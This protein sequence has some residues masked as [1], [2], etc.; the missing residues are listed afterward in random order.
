MIISKHFI[1]GPSYLYI[2]I[3]MW[4]KQAFAFVYMKIKKMKNIFISNRLFPKNVGLMNLW[5]IFD[6]H[7]KCFSNDAIEIC[8]YHVSLINEKLGDSSL[9]GHI[10]INILFFFSE[11]LQFVSHVFTWSS[12]VLNWV[13][14]LLETC[15]TFWNILENGGK[16]WIWNWNWNWIWVKNWTKFEGFWSIFLKKILGSPCY[17]ISGGCLSGK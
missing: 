3:F 8:S 13:C 6:P 10:Y 2:N 4:S 5:K 11:R 9:G 16:I 15:G 17:L 1:L 7:F 12:D 14:L